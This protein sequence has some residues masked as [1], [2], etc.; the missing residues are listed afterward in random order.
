MRKILLPLILSAALPLGG[1]LQTAGNAVSGAVTA[2]NPFGAGGVLDTRNIDL[3]VLASRAADAAEFG[4]HV[5]PVLT[6]I[7][8]IVANIV[9]NALG[10]GEAGLSVEQAVAGAAKTFCDFV[11]ASPAG[12]VIGQRRALSAGPINFGTLIVGGK[13]VPIYGTPK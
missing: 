5:R 9:S 12:V 7:G 13:P 3:G 4:C 2:V 10:L 8:P 11:Q 1:C 6:S